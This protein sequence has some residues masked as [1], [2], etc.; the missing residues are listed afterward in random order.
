VLITLLGGLLPF[1]IVA[2]ILTKRMTIEAPL[3][4]RH[5]FH[6]PGRLA[7]VL[8]TFLGLL[9]AILVIASLPPRTIGERVQS[10]LWLGV[11]VGFIG[12]LI[13]V[14]VVQLGTIRPA[15]ITDHSITLRGVG[16]TFEDAARQA[17][18]EFLREMDRDVGEHWRDLQGRR[19]KTERDR[20]RD[21]R[22]SE[23]V[24]PAH[25]DHLEEP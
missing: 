15:E 17:R 23:Q 4:R 10:V 19:G 7:L 25:D 9:L 16:A 21:P 11:L 20:F 3:C 8:C 6:W 1:I 12:W 2:M 18:S 24:R 13:L 5:R 22:P 14:V